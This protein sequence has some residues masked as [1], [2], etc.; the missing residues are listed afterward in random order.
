MCLYCNFKPFYNKIFSTYVAQNLRP[1]PKVSAQYLRAAQIFCAKY[2]TPKI[3]IIAPVR[4]IEASLTERD[5]TH[6]TL[7]MGPYT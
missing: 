6:G 4:G 2:V 1:P 5:L 7:Y 3:S